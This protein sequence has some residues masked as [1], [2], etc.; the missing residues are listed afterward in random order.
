MSVAYGT[1]FHHG[2]ALAR[3]RHPKQI[4]LIAYTPP[5]A[6]WV[7]P[8]PRDA[9]FLLLLGVL[10]GVGHWMIIGA[11]L[12]APAALVAPFTYVQM[13]WATLYGWL[14]FGQLP[15]GLSALGMGVIVA[16]G[17]GLFVLE[18]RHAARLARRAG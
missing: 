15:D 16:S 9:F 4:V 5:T 18:R 14:V 2:L 17:V 11:F 12:R 7:G 10:A 3:A 13:I 1:N 6:H 8:T